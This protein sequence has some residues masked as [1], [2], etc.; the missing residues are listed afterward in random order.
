MI[1]KV[2]DTPKAQQLKE[3]TEKGGNWWAQIHAGE[4]TVLDEAKW[5]NSFWSVHRRPF[6]SMRITVEHLLLQLTWCVGKETIAAT[7]FVVDR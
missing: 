6:S 7:N 5:E 1:G 2:G 3:N 4:V